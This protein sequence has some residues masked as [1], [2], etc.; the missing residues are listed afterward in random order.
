MYRA[1]PLHI[2]ITHDIPL[3]RQDK[4]LLWPM[5]Y[6]CLGRRY[7][8]S[9]YNESSYNK[10]RPYIYSIIPLEKKT[11]NISCWRSE[12]LFWHNAMISKQTFHNLIANPSP[13]FLEKTWPFARIHQV[14]RPSPQPR[15]YLSSGTP[16]SKWTSFAYDLRCNKVTI[17][18]RRHSP[19]YWFF[20]KDSPHKGQYCGALLL[21]W[22]SCRTNIRWFETP[23][24]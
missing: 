14:A 12:S 7:A 15:S 13:S 20:V 24:Y 9:C 11:R 18:Q 1:V 2:R 21:T 5:I 10:T 16:G 23:W 17:M 4:C 6:L 22:T 3:C 8:V 19:H